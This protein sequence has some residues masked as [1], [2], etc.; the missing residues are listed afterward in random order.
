[1]KKKKKK[2]F[3]ILHD[4]FLLV[5]LAALI[6]T[7]EYNGDTLFNMPQSC[8]ILFKINTVIFYYL[9]LYRPMRLFENS[10]IQRPLP[11]L[12]ESGN[13]LLYQCQFLFKSTFFIKEED[14]EKEI[15]L[16]WP[17]RRK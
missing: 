13:P 11:P 7:M 14:K 2:I 16:Y 8:L 5:A 4:L 9:V 10:Q 3:Y 15:L 17:S 12:S 6:H 1:M